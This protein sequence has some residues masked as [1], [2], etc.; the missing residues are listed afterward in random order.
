MDDIGSV[1]PPRRVTEP[2]LES[3]STTVVDEI[4]H[5]T[6]QPGKISKLELGLVI[7]ICKPFNYKSLKLQSPANR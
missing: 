6:S 4:P 1:I 3:E 5:T 7:V 2:S